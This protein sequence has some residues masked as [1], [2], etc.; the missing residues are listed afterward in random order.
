M[1]P[2]TGTLALN[3][4]CSTEGNGAQGI[5]VDP[6]G[7]FTLIANTG[8]NDVSIGVPDVGELATIAAGMSP[9][10]ITFDPTYQVVYVANSGDNTV[11]SY[12]LSIASP[13]LTPIGPQLANQ[14]TVSFE[15]LE[16]GDF[17]GIESSRE[18]RVGSMIFRLLSTWPS[19]SDNPSPRSD[20]ALERYPYRV[21]SIGYEL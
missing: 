14:I 4:S 2:S 8:S 6:F 19:Q 16:S 10:A 20:S 7:K 21:F 12:V 5:A 13:Y 9:V 3:C 1:N 11:S 17:C 18:R 15:F